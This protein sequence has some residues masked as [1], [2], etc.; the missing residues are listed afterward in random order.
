[1]TQLD[2]AKAAYD[3]AEADRIAAQTAKDENS[4]DQ[5]RAALIAARDNA[6]AA[7]KTW[8]DADAAEALV[9]RPD[10]QTVADRLGLELP[11]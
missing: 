4:N 2:D 10:A 9:G 3:Q 5:T 1:M 8:C 6:A 7:Q 11:A